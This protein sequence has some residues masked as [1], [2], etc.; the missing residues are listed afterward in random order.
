MGN[1]Q[2]RSAQSGDENPRAGR[3]GLVG[4]S[5]LKA[6]PLPLHYLQRIEEGSSPH[7]VLKLSLSFPCYRVTLAFFLN[8]L[9]G[10]E[11]FHHFTPW[12]PEWSSSPPA[13]LLDLFFTDGIDPVIKQK[14]T[15]VG[16]E[17]AFTT[18]SLG[19]PS[20]AVLPPP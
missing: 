4:I 16:L 13:L 12:V 3:S 9:G 2:T 11:F 14:K 5:L 10:G 15:R 19:S 6:P 18:P 17:K 20:G 8:A 1:P 7:A